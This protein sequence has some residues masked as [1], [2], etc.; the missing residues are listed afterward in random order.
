MPPRSRAVLVAGVALALLIPGQALAS[1]IAYTKDNNIWLMSPDGSRNVQVTKDG[2][3]S[4]YYTFPSQADDGTILAKHGDSFVR[5]RPDGTKIGAPVPGLGSDTQHSGNVF[6]MAGP[7]GP[8]ISPDGRRFAYWI[9][10]RSMVTC[11]IWDPGCSYRD[12]D[13]TIVSDV[14]GFTDPA[15]YGSVRDYRDPSWV[16]N[17]ALL[18]F[19]YGLGVKEAALSPVGAGEPGL[20]QWFDPPGGLPQI[21]Q[22]V[23]TRLGDKIATLGGSEAFGPSQEYVLLYGVSAGHPTPPDAKCMVS[24]A[25]AP[26]K[27]FLAPSW[28]PDGTELAVTE[29]DGI[30]VFSNIPDLRAESPNCTQITDRVL[31]AG[32]MPAWG[33]ADVPAGSPVGP[34]QGGNGQP[35]A[36]AMTAL[37]VA[38]RQKGRAIRVRVGVAVAGSAVRVRLLGKRNR[39]MGSATKVAKNAGTLTL[40]VRL[41]SKGRGALRRA[42]KLSLSVRVSVS[43]PGRAAA[44]A[45]RAVTLRR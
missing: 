32:A 9:S 17:D 45:T 41:N 37:T 3:S 22:G 7:G 27:K 44:S 5:L 33:P 18:V 12:T 29:S 15:K 31:V 30:H 36:S 24:D 40:K 11:P 39:V 20:E 14:D 8:Q 42:R 16:G 4:R 2:T 38:K 6:V 35:P 25:A 10:V 28:S 1:S 43:G 21:G 34:Q 26:S 23:M 13:Y 19:N